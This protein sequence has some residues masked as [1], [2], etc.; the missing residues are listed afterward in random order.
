[1]KKVQLIYTKSCVYCPQTK[2]L[3]KELNQKHKFD[4]EE[5]DAESSEGQKL[6]Q[7]FDIMSVPTIIIDSKVAFVGLPTRERAEAAVKN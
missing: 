6:V 2:A 7:K 5:I 1:M 4:Y 3:F